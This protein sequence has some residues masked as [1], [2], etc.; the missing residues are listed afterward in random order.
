MYSCVLQAKA[1]CAL[2]RPCMGYHTRPTD[3][4]L[5]CDSS[6]QTR[7][8]G[9]VAYTCDTLSGGWEVR[10]DCALGGL[11]CGVKE[12]STTDKEAFCGAGTCSKGDRP[13]CKESKLYKCV[14]G[15]IEIND[16]PAQGLQCRDDLAGVCE[17][18]GVSC[19]EM[20]PTCVGN[21]LTTC[22]N[23]Y[24]WEID[25]AKL[26]GKKKCDST[27]ATPSCLGAGS[28]C[29]ADAYWN[30]CDADANTLLTC[31]DGAIKKWD[32]KD[33]GFEGCEEPQLYKAYCKAKPIY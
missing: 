12:T 20:N 10:I 16:C 13:Y 3:P 5:L 23:G 7:C 33:M 2:I 31:V 22:Q 9:E 1:D 26:P 18:T 21:V 4:K 24:K 15:A 25:C 32:C 30:K 8:V 11:R 27:S 19:K 14:G 29:Q 6:Y 17:G 28:E